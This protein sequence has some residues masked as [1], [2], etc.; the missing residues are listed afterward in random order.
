M[1]LYKGSHTATPPFLSPR[2]RFASIHIK[3]I[4]LMLRRMNVMVRLMI[5]MTVMMVV[6]AKMVMMM[7]R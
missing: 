3:I 2:Q 1:K 4:M 5:L 6:V 7:T